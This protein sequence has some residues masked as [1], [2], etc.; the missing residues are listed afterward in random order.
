M[1]PRMK[2]HG[3]PEIT[4]F[5]IHS[6]DCPNKTKGAFYKGC[7]CWKHLRWSDNGKQIRISAKERT[8]EGAERKKGEVEKTYYRPAPLDW[9][10]EITAKIDRLT[11]LVEA[12]LKRGR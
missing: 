5:V 2:I 9:Y 1:K 4:I 6:A 7:E 10:D 3:I 12:S 11:G 8:W